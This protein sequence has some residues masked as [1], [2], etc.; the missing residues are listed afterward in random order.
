VA[1]PFVFL[2][3]SAVALGAGLYSLK[4]GRH[5]SAI[6]REG[7]RREA[8]AEVAARHANKPQGP[9]A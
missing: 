5:E 9:F 7:K 2:A 1:A 3:G 4:S 6:E 8:D